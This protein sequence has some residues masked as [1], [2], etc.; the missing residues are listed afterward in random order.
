MRKIS[1]RG[2]L[3]RLALFIAAAIALALASCCR[4]ATDLQVHKWERNH[5][6]EKPLRGAWGIHLF[7]KKN[8]YKY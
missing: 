7:Q 3:L 5:K 2:F 8:V 4:P 1:I 6:F